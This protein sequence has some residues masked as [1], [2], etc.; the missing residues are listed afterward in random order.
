MSSP[1][2]LAKFSTLVG[3][4]SE[5]PKEARRA[6]PV[7]TVMNT[8]RDHDGMVPVA[9]LRS[10]TDLRDEVIL[11]VVEQLRSGERVEIVEIN[12]VKF[13]RLTPAGYAYFAA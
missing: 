7:D 12:Q 9:E 13:I 5:S 11:K 2:S 4:L 8:L 10:L 6:D 1:S 3:S